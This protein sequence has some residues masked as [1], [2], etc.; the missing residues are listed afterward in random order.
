MHSYLLPLPET[1]APPDFSPYPVAGLTEV[2]M[3]TCALNLFRVPL[4]VRMSQ[5]HVFTAG[6]WD[7]V[8][9]RPRTTG[10]LPQLQEAA[11]APVFQRTA[12]RV[13]PGTLLF[14]Q[15]VLP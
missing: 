11:G 8:A 12:Y 3:D 15:G 4:G 6:G 9:W 1:P 5:Q 10:T 13:P 14:S 2:E 7:P